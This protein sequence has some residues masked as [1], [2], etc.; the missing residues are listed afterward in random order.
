MKTLAILAALLAVMGIAGAWEETNYLSYQFN[1]VVDAQAD[2]FPEWFNGVSSYASFY[3]YNSPYGYES[4]YVD[5][6]ASSLSTTSP[7]YDGQAV[8]THD[9]LTQYGS[10]TVG[11]KAPDLEA[12]GDVMR[13]GTATAGQNMALSGLYTSASFSGYDYA[14][15]NGNDVSAYTYP[16]YWSN[17]PTVSV[18]AGGDTQFVEADMGTAATIGF[19][20][21]MAPGA[22]PTMSGGFQ[23]WGEFDGAFD[24]TVDQWGDRV[25]E[26]YV[27]LPGSGTQQFRMYSWD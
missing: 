26:M 16:D 23:A 17:Y 15:V 19:E 14:G 21:L 12:P 8:D 27:D 25:A 6:Y 4:A 22:Y 2:E 1:K 9:V 10:A 5:N 20:Q 13:F 11:S 7:L 24:P 3:S 18:W